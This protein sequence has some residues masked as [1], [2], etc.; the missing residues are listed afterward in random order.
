M[1][2]IYT[3]GLTTCKHDLML[4]TRIFEKNYN[5]EILPKSLSLLLQSRT[6][7]YSLCIIYRNL[8]ILCL[9]TDKLVIKE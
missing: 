8:F 4:T 2:D 5:V 9:S 7:G 3:E 6:Y 1:F